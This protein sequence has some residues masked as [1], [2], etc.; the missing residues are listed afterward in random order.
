MTTAG[1][2]ERMRRRRVIRIIAV[3]VTSALVYALVV[4]LY[5]ANSRT[6]LG[7]P[8]PDAG[9]DGAL[10]LSLSPERVDAVGN[11]IVAT[12]DVE[13]FGEVADPATGL[14]ADPLVLLVQGTA[15]ERSVTL[16]PDQLPPSIALDLITEG[17]V[18]QWPF[19]AHRADFAI[20]ALSVAGSGERAVPI[21]LCGT[22]RVPGW[23][24]AS[25]ELPGSDDLV[26][27]GVPV[28][29]VQ[30]V[31]SRAAATIAF[32][33]VLLVLMIVLPV[34]ALTVAIAVRRGRRRAEA[35][36]LSWIA[37]MLFATIPL[38]TF[39]PGSPP[40]GSWVDFLIVL[41]VVAG[42]VAALVVYVLGWMAWSAPGPAA[43]GEAADS[44][45]VGG[46]LG[47]GSAAPSD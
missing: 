40:I 37:A 16:E 25:A 35:T 43:V 24:F 1:A 23:T 39:L 14:L 10:V 19:D 38:R 30:I 29:Q 36:L 4:A 28:A 17:A 22:A 32:G 34:L 5:A 11:R 26:V 12:L 8:C 6:A 2:G 9:P 33:I 46:G 7:A 21:F 45:T 15:G 31:A 18:E 3:L 47:D 41:W 20:V 42:L 27:D 44:P 13:D